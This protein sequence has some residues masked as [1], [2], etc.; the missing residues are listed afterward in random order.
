MD[1]TN[2]SLLVRAG[3]RNDQRS[4]REYYALYA[5]L[6]RRHA[7]H[8]GLDANDAEDV[9]Q[10]SMAALL[11]A[12]PQFQYD[13]SKGRFRSYVRRMVQNKISNRLRQRRS[14]QL[15]THAMAT[16]AAQSDEVES[17]W[18]R[19]WQRAHLEYCLEQVSTRFAPEKLAAFRAYALEGQD[20]AAVCKRYKLTPNQVY[21][22]KSRIVRR[23]RS[24]LATLVG[25]VV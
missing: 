16:L 7:G 18:D 11:K 5:P 21:L 9:V 1:S 6:I 23:L 10:E 2:E 19:D 20:I 24:E 15:R 14:K 12:L 3:N 13:R 17:V 25:D 22:A 4:W 8:C